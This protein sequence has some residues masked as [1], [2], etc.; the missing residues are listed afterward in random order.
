MDIALECIGLARS[1]VGFSEIILY[2]LR[3]ES[4][5]K[6]LHTIIHP[7]FYKD[8]QPNDKCPCGSGM[9]YKKCCQIEVEAVKRCK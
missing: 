5:T 9:K 1:V 3:C 7:R 6:G 2:I 8:A 4:R